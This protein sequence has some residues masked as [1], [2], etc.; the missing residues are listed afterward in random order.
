M[1]SGK[2]TNE[3]QGVGRMLSRVMDTHTVQLGNYEPTQ[4]FTE[5]LTKIF[6]Q[7]KILLSHH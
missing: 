1:S 4:P 6:G 2:I 7:D 5:T 3:G